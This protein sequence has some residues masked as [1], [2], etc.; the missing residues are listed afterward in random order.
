[1]AFWNNWLKS[2]IPNFW[3]MEKGNHYI[4]LYSPVDKASSVTRYLS[5][6]ELSFKS[7]IS[8]IVFPE[9]K[10]EKLAFNISKWY[11]SNLNKLGLLSSLAELFRVDS[12][13]ILLGPYL[14]LKLFFLLN[15]LLRV[16]SSTAGASLELEIGVLSLHLNEYL[17]PWI[18]CC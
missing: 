10:F 16:S 11:D 13:L 15:K 2:N 5:N 18:S 9:V 12:F 7:L 3:F 1:M 8:S 14:C 6:S 17:F 4:K